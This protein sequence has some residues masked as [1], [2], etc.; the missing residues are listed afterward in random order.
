MPLPEFKQLVDEAKRQIQE[1]GPADLA[2]MEQ[3]KQN[4]VVIDVRESDEQAKGMIPGAVAMPRGI[5]ERDIDQ[6]TTDKQRPIVLYCASGG[7]SALAALALQQMGFTTVMSLNGG[8][9]G[10][11]ESQSK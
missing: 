6:V 4:V 7:R 8:Y 10:W 5:L 11:S 9:K 3:S 1:V 2:K